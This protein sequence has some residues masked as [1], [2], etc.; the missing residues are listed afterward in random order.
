LPP[1]ALDLAQTVDK[2]LDAPL[3]IALRVAVD[4]ELDVVPALNDCEHDGFRL[5]AENA[6]GPQP[7]SNVLVSMF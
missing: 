5:A 3:S 7:A 2:T 4:S 1:L 6:V